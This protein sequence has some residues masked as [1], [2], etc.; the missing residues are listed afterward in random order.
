MPNARNPLLQPGIRSDH[1]AGAGRKRVRRFLKLFPE[2][3]QTLFAI[4]FKNRSD[5][6]AKA[7]AQFLLI[8]GRWSQANS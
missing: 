4:L 6:S 7:T 3:G 2:I 5:T 1:F 8:V